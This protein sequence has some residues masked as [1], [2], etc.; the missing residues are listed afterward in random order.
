MNSSETG[1]ISSGRCLERRG[2][3]QK[4][5]GCAVSGQCRSP[6]LVEIVRITNYR[7]SMCYQERK[8]KSA[9]MLSLPLVTPFWSSSTLIPLPYLHILIVL[10]L[11]FYI[12]SSIS[13]FVNHQSH[14]LLHWYSFLSSFHPDKFLER[15]LDLFPLFSVGLPSDRAKKYSSSDFNNEVFSTPSFPVFSSPCLVCEVSES[16]L[17]VRQACAWPP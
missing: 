4:S 10:I 7:L 5:A 12:K 16:S 11:T 1:G 2:C 8:R 14:R 6:R 13:S 17:D 9:S 3:L 15:A